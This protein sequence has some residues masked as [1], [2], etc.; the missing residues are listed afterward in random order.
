MTGNFWVRSMDFAGPGVVQTAPFYRELWKLHD[1]VSG[2]NEGIY[3]RG[4]S[5]EPYL[6]GLHPGTRRGLQRI[7]FGVK[8]R[9]A[10]EEKRS[11]IV[12]K[13]IDATSIAP[14]ATPGGGIGFELR[15]P[16][17][18]TLRFS[19]DVAEAPRLNSTDDPMRISHIVLNTP[20][21]EIVQQFLVD[22]LGFRVADFSEDQMVFLRCHT[23]HH[24][25]ALNRADHAS[26][27]HV[28]FE[29]SD[30]DAYMRGIGRMKNGGY[31]LNWGPGRHG[32][33]DNVFAYWIGPSGFVIE[34]TTALEQ[35][36]DDREPKVWQ[37]TAEQS[38]RWMLAG[39]PNR[40]V[41]VAMAGEPD[42][43][44]AE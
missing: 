9:A 40:Q 27:N 4:S 10:L 26:V 38:D 39:P 33:G 32:P 15:D 13:G 12:A 8:D 1:T 37:R 43:G 2:D 25:I 3:L 44:P 34:Y 6:L 16:D 22:I 18:R 14:L 42:P 35:V 5:S 36:T 30:I 7:T 20:Q 17:N 28:A 21:M 24:S 23:D 31:P 19:T 41:R 11:Q 29:L